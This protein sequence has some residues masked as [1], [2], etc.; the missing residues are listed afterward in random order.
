[1][2]R[3]I[4]MT[5]RPLLLLLLVVTSLTAT[6]QEI[7]SLAGVRFTLDRAGARSL[8]MGSTA[9]TSTDASAVAANPAAIAGAPR[10][11]SIEQRRRTM[12]GRYVVDT[13][14]STIGIESETSG[15]RS[16]FLVVPAAGL[17]WAVSYD[18]PLD[19]EHSTTDDEEIQE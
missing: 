13:N 11:F 15:I 1:M 6:A 18:E 5:P 14:L 19:V 2:E 3:R 17:T 12:E 4:R 10:S 9:I 7:E 8:A 16:A